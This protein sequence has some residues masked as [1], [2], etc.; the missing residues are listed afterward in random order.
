MEEDK[1]YLQII[2]APLLSVSG[3]LRV[4]RIVDER[5]ILLSVSVNKVDMGKIL[6]KTGETARAIRRIMHQFGASRQLHL[7]VKF[8]EP[9]S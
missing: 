8:N 3:E 1:Q 7:S 2:I 6:G 5:G 4:D 9:L